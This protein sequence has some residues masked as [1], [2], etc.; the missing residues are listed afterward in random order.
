MQLRNTRERY[1]AIPKFLHWG[2][3]GLF[4][5]AW[6]LG[7]F[8]DAFPR[9]AARA[10]AQFVQGSADLAMAALLIVRVIWRIADPPPP[11]ESTFLG[12]ILDFFAQLSHFGLY[13]LMFAVVAVGVV[14]TFANGDALPVFGFFDIASPWP[15]DRALARA[16]KEAHD[17]LS[18]ALMALAAV[19]AAA[20]LVH[21]W[22]FRDRTLVRM[23]PGAMR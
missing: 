21:H 2:V 6:L 5:L 4:V 19:H 23:L 7:V 1:G 18:N 9:G 11:P 16:S 3:A 12:E 13:A 10:G 14:A 22:F 17:V 8:G 15:A 20:A